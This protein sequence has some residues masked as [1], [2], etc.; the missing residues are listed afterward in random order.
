[1]TKEKPGS[2]DAL[3]SVVD[4]EN[5][6]KKNISPR[7]GK[8]KRKYTKR[9]AKSSA[10][11][12]APTVAEQE[13]VITNVEL[14]GIVSNDLRPRLKAEMEARILV[15]DGE[16]GE[17]VEQIRSLTAKVALLQDERD[18]VRAALNTLKES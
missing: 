14:G 16:E 13:E 12:P 11:K 17:A 9:A 8:P 10:P 18:R 7:T 5:E 2:L 4:A 3:M 15:I 1:M 6:A